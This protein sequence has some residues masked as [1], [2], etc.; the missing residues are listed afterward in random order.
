MLN[1]ILCAIAGGVAGWVGYSFMN[2]NEKRGLL[3]SMA[4]GLLGGLLGGRL[5]ATIMGAGAASPDDFNPF[6]L[7]FSFTSAAAILIVSSIVHKRFG[8]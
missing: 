1:I 2:L 5:T 4:V 6:L 3:V 8:F 7:L